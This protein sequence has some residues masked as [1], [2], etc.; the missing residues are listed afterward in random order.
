[1]KIRVAVTGLYSG[2]SMKMKSETRPQ[3]DIIFQIE[4]DEED[5]QEVVKL[6]GGGGGKGGA[7]DDISSLS[8]VATS[9]FRSSSS[10]AT[11]RWNIFNPFF[12][13]IINQPAN[14]RLLLAAGRP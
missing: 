11:F 4:T 10:L 5:G 1:M 9:F 12:S 6:L 8:K 7:V 3:Q 13:L 14:R 2:D